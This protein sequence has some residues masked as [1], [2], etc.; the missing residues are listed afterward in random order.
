MH[1]INPK[2]IIVIIV[3]CANNEKHFTQG[4][5]LSSVGRKKLFE[6]LLL[7]LHA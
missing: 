6:T 5:V 3:V 4:L 2:A 7:A 1:F